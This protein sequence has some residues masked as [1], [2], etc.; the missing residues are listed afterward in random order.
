MPQ[1]PTLHSP[2]LPETGIPSACTLRLYQFIDLQ[3]SPGC[4]PRANVGVGGMGRVENFSGKGPNRVLADG[5]VSSGPG[6][7]GGRVKRKVL[8]PGEV[9]KSSVMRKKPSS[10]ALAG[11]GPL[12]GRPF[13]CWGLKGVQLHCS[14]LETR[15]RCGLDTPPSSGLL[16]EGRRWYGGPAWEERGKRGRWCGYASPG[17]GARPSPTR[18]GDRPSPPRVC[19]DPTP[20]SGGERRPADARVGEGGRG[21][22]AGRRKPTT[23]LVSRS[24][25]LDLNGRSPRP[26]S[27]AETREGAF[28]RWGRARRR[29]AAG[30]GRAGP[31]G[32]AEQGQRTPT[33]PL[34][35]PAPAA[36][37]E[38]GGRG[39]HLA[40]SAG[41]LHLVHGG[42]PSRGGPT[43]PRPGQGPFLLSGQRLVP[44][45]GLLPPRTSGRNPKADWKDAGGRQGMRGAGGAGEGRGPLCFQPGRR[46]FSRPLNPA[47]PPSGLFTGRQRPRKGQRYA[48][49]MPRQVRGARVSAPQPSASRWRSQSS[50]LPAWCLSTRLPPHWDGWTEEG[51]EVG[52][53]SAPSL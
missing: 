39:P 38:R 11:R 14:R 10:E 27:A 47:R 19:G 45:L 50:Q 15:R 41:A 8:V 5:P 36:A 13:R 28:G 21:G 4:G 20:V 3:S 35:R 31:G 2:C 32:R 43:P 25:R 12:S 40:P 24:A 37:P 29:R 23:K 17:T 53:R 7:Q 49:G 6:P 52:G 1:E 18:G 22:E 44:V 26:R 34:V 30:T 46:V 48:P 16:E 9:A 33:S 51:R 42:E